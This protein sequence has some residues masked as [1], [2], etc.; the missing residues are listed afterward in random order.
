[1]IGSPETVI[2]VGNAANLTGDT[3]VAYP[4]GGGDFDV[5]TNGFTLKLDS[6]NGNPFAYSGAISGAGNVEFYTGPTATD[7]R[8]APKVITGPKPNMATGKF[9]VKKG[10]VQLTKPEGVVAT[11]GD[12]VVGGHGLNDCSGS[13]ATSSRIR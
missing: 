12:V 7:Y 13:T 8:D 3:T 5:R 6:R 9:L 1:L 11:S 2:G 4:S 10:R